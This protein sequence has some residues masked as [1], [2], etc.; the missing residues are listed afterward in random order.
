LSVKQKVEKYIP[1]SEDEE[2]RWEADGDYDD[3]DIEKVYV[4]R[5]SFAR[6]TA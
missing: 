1:A 6:N 2:S 4:G 5:V 3:L